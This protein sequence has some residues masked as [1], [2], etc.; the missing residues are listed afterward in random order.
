MNTLPDLR[1]IEYHLT[2]HCNLNC[3]GCG[4]FSPFA[5]ET[6]ANPDQFE[7]DISRL[8]KLF[9]NIFKIRL[10]GGEPLLHPEPESFMLIARKYFPQS[11][12]RIVT[13]GTLLK[14][15]RS[16]F[17]KA[18]RDAN[19]TIDISL[20][21]PLQKLRHYFEKLCTS[22]HVRCNISPVND[23]L[24]FFNTKGSSLPEEAMSSCRSLFYCPFLHNSRLHVCAASVMARYY[25]ERFGHQI[26]TDIGIDIFA[27]DISGEKILELLSMPVATCA[28]CQSNYQVV[29]W[30]Q[31]PP[32]KHR[33]Q[34][35]GY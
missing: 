33:T 35:Y 29:Q 9:T 30:E 26:D 23:F 31:A 17:W 14:A 19:I 4:H 13:N 24:L 10:M 25:N 34:D 16:E 5:P 21:P 11:D 7:I 32:S 1:Y 3:R 2:D 22:H 6:F 18:C 27:H 8:S 20:Y 15:A 12:I 28:F